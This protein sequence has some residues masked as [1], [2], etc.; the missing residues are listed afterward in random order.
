MRRNYTPIFRDVINSRVWALS[1]AARAVWLWL[2]LVA[3]PEGCVCSDVTGVAMGARVTGPEAREA[4]ELLVL[5]D[6]DADPGDPFQGRI[7]ERV[8]GGWRVLG[9]EDRRELAKEEARNARNRK[10]MQRARSVPA[11]DAGADVDACVPSVSPTKP[12]P[13]TKTKTTPPTGVGVDPPTPTP[14]PTT[15]TL[16]SLS[17]TITE[18]PTDWAPS[19]ELRAEATI[20]GVLSLDE[21]IKRLRRGPIGGSRGIFEHEFHNYIRDM[22]PK[23]RTWEETDRAKAST[24]LAVASKPRAQGYRAPTLTI[25]ATPKHRAYAE[26]HNLPLDELVRDLNASGAVDDLGA[27]RAL[28]MLGEKMGRLVR[29]QCDRLIAKQAQTS[30]EAA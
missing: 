26:K 15:T 11:N 27:K 25:E 8:R 21:H 12:K 13:K 9:A 3:D 1:P 28:E 5:E 2:S 17:R 6:A 20:A 23:M 22:L 14:T 10:Y 30:P 16:V 7:I 19:P 18:V 29:E 24:A 4:L